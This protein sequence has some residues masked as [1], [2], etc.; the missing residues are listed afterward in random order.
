M[1]V[2]GWL[3]PP[4]SSAITS[5]PTHRK[6][7]CLVKQMCKKWSNLRLLVVVDVDA[8]GKCDMAQTKQRKQA[9]KQAGYGDM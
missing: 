3:S 6:E 1:V 8:D 5:N 7:V 9:S 2:I 4:P